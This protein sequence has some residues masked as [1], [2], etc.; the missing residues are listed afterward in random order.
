[1]DERPAARPTAGPLSAGAADAL[2]PPKPRLGCFGIGCIGILA[3]VAFAVIAGLIGSSGGERTT[4]R[5]VEARIYC[6]DEIRDRLKAPS[7]AEF[8]SS[9]SGTDPVVVQGTVDAENSFGAMVR[10]SFQCSVTFSGDTYRLRV[11]NFG[12]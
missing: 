9:Y 6:E 11:D 3:L 2:K 12:E 10:N 4:D 7:T 1:M 8:E 5:G